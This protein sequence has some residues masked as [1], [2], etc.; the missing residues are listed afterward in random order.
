MIYRAIAIETPLRTLPSFK[1]REASPDGSAYVLNLFESDPVHTPEVEYGVAIFEYFKDGKGHFSGD[2]LTLFLAIHRIT[3]EEAFRRAYL[4]ADLD[5][6]D[7]EHMIRLRESCLL[8]AKNDDLGIAC[9]CFSSSSEYQDSV[10]EAWRKPEPRID[11]MHILT[12]RAGL[13]ATPRKFDP[14]RPSFE[15]Y[16]DQ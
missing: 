2:L 5:P 14:E 13:L 11:M 1:R 15:S 7:V 16:I 12:L 3:V 4:V 10:L 6:E 9:Y 8:L